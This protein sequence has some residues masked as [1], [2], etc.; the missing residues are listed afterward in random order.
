VSALGWLVCGVGVGWA[1]MG[2]LDE[3]ITEW[4][5]RRNNRPHDWEKEWPEFKIAKE[6]HVKRLR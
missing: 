2:L 5:S 3:I 6:S 1:A 4:W